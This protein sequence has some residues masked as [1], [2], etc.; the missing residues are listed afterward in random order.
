MTTRAKNITEPKK[1]HDHSSKHPIPHAFLVAGNLNKIEPTCYSQASTDA[2]WH[3]AMN[4][5]F[6]SL[7]KNNTWH[8]VPASETHNL[9]G[10][11]WVF[12]IKRKADGSID[13][14]KAK[15]VA[16]G[17]HQQAGIGYE[18]TFSPI[19]KPT[20]VRLVLSIAISSSWSIR[21]IDIQNAFL[22]GVLT[23]KFYISQAPSYSHPQY[24]NHVCRL[25]KALYGLKQA[26]QAWFSRLSNKLL[27]FGFL[28]SKS[29]TSS[30][31]NKSIALTMFVLIYA[32]DIIIT[33][34][35]S[36]A[37]NNLL[38]QVKSDF[39]VKDLGDLNFFL[40]IE[41]SSIS[42]GIFLS[43]KCYMLNILKRTKMVDA[44]PICTPMATSM[45]L[46]AFDR[47]QLLY[48]WCKKRE[49]S[50]LHS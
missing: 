43:Q 47:E 42:D 48:G 1:F 30:F 11:K 38:L 16:K 27:D 22:H 2:N 9:V 6:D 13:R 37:T 19:I 35:N 4:S 45:T 15:L 21:R 50:A 49:F 33:S 10:F 31:I 25:Q 34:S 5:E 18:E 7:L 29:D 36:T 28:A 3:S 24:S 26:P 41:V 14:Y 40:G 12:R 8:L 20:T 32:D 17:F 39:D 44:K 23:E 46:F